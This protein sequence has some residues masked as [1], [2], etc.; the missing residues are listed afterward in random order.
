[1]KKLLLISIIAVLF[2]DSATAQVTVSYCRVGVGDGIE[3]G[4]F[5][6]DNFYFYK[7]KEI[8]FYKN[9]IQYFP[10]YDATVLSIE[11]PYTDENKSM[12]QNIEKRRMMM[13]KQMHKKRAVGFFAT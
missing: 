2:A 10:E 6:C 13:W 4:E 1:M 3:H 12:L 11:M 9:G 7:A 8:R 5:T